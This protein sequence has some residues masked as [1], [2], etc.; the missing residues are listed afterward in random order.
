MISIQAIERLEHIRVL[1]KKHKSKVL[2]F[3]ENRNNSDGMILDETANRFEEILD[4]IGRYKKLIVVLDSR[5]GSISASWRI[6]ILV[7]SRQSPTM[8]TIPE[9]AKSSATLIALAANQII[10]LENAE[11]GPLDP[12]TE[13]EG[14]NVSALDLMNSTDPV[15]RSR[16]ERVVNQMREYISLLV[17]EEEVANRLANRLLLL[18]EQHASHISP[19]F[20]DEAKS[21]GLPVTVEMDLDVRALHVMY[22]RCNF[23]EH[24]PSTVIEYF[25]FNDV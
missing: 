1:D 23:C 14:Q 8:V 21:L 11:L 9:K 2:T 22:K 13:Y 10:M 25:P 17:K 5:G 4:K 19:I 7:K 15:L 16:A 6:A 24:H 12:Q 20:F 18:D 3:Y